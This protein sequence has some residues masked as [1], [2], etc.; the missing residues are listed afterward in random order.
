[1]LVRQ[2]K[3]PFEFGR[4]DGAEWPD[5]QI[6]ALKLFCLATSTA[7]RVKD[8]STPNYEIVWDIKS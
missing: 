8:L 4:S 1:M 3:N 6:V 2:V 7:S 5:L